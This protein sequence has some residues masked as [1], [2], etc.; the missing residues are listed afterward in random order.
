MPTACSRASTIDVTNDDVPT[1]TVDIAVDEI[2]EADGTAATTATVSRNTDTTNP[3]TVTLT[4][5]DTSE[6]AVAANVT[7]PAG[8]SS[9]TFNIDAI[10]DAIVDGTQTVTILANC[11]VDGRTSEGFVVELPP[12]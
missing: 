4:S 7:I 6:A 11:S 9:F 2:S 10:D 3:L 5:D 8:Q 1:L 12:R